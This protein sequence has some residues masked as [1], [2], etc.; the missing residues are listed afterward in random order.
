MVAPWN[1]ARTAAND[2]VSQHEAIGGKHMLEVVS[3]RAKMLE[4]IDRSFTIEL[5]FL[6][7]LADAGGAQ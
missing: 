5:A 6:S 4:Q 7:S 2:I 1:A 3:R